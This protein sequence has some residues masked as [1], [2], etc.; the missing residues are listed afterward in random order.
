MGKAL[1]DGRAGEKEVSV[2]CLLD[3]GMYFEV[4]A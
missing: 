4:K 2:Y 1:Q 3:G